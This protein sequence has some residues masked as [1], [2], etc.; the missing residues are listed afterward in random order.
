ML[1]FMVTENT[2]QTGEN[3]PALKRV[4]GPR[5]LFFFVIGDILGT[6]IY[7]LTGSVAGRVGG[8]LWLPFLIAFLVAFLTAF[9]YLELVGKYPR[10][11]GAA[12]Y[13]NRAFRKPFLTFIVAFAVMCS[14]ITSASAAARAFGATYLPEAFDIEVSGTVIAIVAVLF[15]LL[16]AGINFI[17][18]AHSVKTNVVLTCVELAG[19]AI[20]IGVGIYA[21]AGGQGEPGRLVEINTADTN[22]LLAV[23]AA[24][25]LAFFA[26]VGFEDSV[27]MAEETRDP[28]RTFPK[29]LLS[30]MAVAALIYVLVALTSS[31]LIAADDLAAAESGALLEVIGVGAPDFPRWIFEWIGMFAVVNSALINMLM[32]SRLLYGMAN[33]RILPKVFGTVHPFRRTPW[34]SILVTS[35]IAAVLVATAGEDGVSKLGGTTALLLLCVFLVV[36]ISVLVLR[37]ESVEHPHFRA[38]TWAPITAG[39]LCGYLA[40]P[41][42]SGRPASDYYIALVLIALGMLLWV[43][44][45][46]YLRGRGERVTEFDPQALND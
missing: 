15:V 35:A 36:N 31:L 1:W 37:R 23:T 10:A 45:W 12:L 38:P 16:L 21:V 24:S 34:V 26:M 11:A 32:A 25:S 17:G 42:L 27:N 19:L 33:E 44:N 46:L 18:V 4:M 28:N 29:A 30:G 13:T 14:G 41:W 22:W 2:A 43:V 20:I 9:A 40:V 5:L 7:A 6:G 8:A 3:Q 39:I